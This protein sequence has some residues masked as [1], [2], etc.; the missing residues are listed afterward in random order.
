M[1]S[2]AGAKDGGEYQLILAVASLRAG[3]PACITQP[4]DSGYDF[5][6]G[7][8][9]PNHSL[10][11]LKGFLNKIPAVRIDFKNYICP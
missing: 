8:A 10:T 6:P 1:F 9:S 3:I 4:A 11:D 7:K 2:P 5:C